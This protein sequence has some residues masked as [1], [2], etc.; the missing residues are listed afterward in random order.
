MILFAPVRTVVDNGAVKIW[1][2]GYLLS[3]NPTNQYISRYYRCGVIDSDICPK[4]S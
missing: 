1:A 3:N 2:S 4:R